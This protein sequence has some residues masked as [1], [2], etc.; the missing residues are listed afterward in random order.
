MIFTIFLKFIFILGGAA[1][2][3][4]YGSGFTKMMQHLAAPAQQ[5]Y[6]YTDNYFA[7]N[8]Q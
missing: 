4:S 3:V 7:K 1:G 5:H 8:V 6:L 2:D